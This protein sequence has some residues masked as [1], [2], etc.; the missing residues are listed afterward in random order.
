LKLAGG[1]ELSKPITER[2][3]PLM[4][5]PDNVLY[6]EAAVGFGQQ[7]SIRDKVSP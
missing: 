1:R 2:G 6:R 4:T 3:P 5:V 7:I